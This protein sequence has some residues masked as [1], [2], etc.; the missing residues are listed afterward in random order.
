MPGGRS[1][2]GGVRTGTPGSAYPQ[3]T[4]LNVNR[5]LPITAPTGLPY[6]EHKALIDT[7]QQVPIQT[8]APT[9][10][11]L[12]PPPEPQAPPAP[13]TPLSAPTTRPQEPITAG[14]P[15]GPGPGP[16]ALG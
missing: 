5:T 7:Q 8:P 6:G 1:R 11:G 10:T 15:T 14:L 4:D 13:I 2:R 16:E 9:P 12:L 3:R